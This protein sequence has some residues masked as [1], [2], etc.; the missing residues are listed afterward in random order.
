ME[1]TNIN[2]LYRNV[3][4]LLNSFN[5][6]KEIHFMQTLSAVS[7]THLDVDK[8]QIKYCPIQNIV[9]LCTV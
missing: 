3:L 5:A 1:V 9:Y 2:E 4:E 6:A 7:Y 8:R